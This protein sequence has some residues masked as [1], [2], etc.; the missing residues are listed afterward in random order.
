MSDTRD[1]CDRDKLALEF[2]LYTLP[3]LVTLASTGGPASDP[4]RSRA[5]QKQLWS[6]VLAFSR[7]LRSASQRAG[8]YQAVEL[9]KA[10]GAK[11]RVNAL[12]RWPTASA[13]ES[14][15]TSANPTD[16]VAALT[17]AVQRAD[18][19]LLWLERARAWHPSEDCPER[20]NRLPNQRAEDS[21]DDQR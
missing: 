19:S 6:E 20:E 1:H 2:V 15:P 5:R 8:E 11:R 13:V 12:L 21:H 14:A 3:R 17:R 9:E 10:A 16:L 18:P 7:S 4:R